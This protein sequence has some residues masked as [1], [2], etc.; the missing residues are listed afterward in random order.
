LSNN[1]RAHS[2]FPTAPPHLAGN[3]YHS[4]Q[5]IATHI[6]LF[7]S[8]DNCAGDSEDEG[9]DDQYQGAYNFFRCMSITLTRWSSN[10]HENHIFTEIRIA[11]ST[12]DPIS[13]SLPNSSYLTTGMLASGCGKQKS[14]YQEC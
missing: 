6:A 9:S 8:K 12:Y 5:T 14:H 1:L 7:G 3:V 10:P 11:S 2:K 13:P 4:R